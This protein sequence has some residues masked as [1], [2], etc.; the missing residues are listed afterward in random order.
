[1]NFG[2]NELKTT[3]RLGVLQKNGVITNTN[4]YL[5]EQYMDINGINECVV[6]CRYR[7]GGTNEKTK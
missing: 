1:M 7:K 2:N 3:K 5:I 6:I 4:V